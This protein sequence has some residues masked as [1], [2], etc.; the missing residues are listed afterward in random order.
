MRIPQL[1]PASESLE[2]G[3]EMGKS[4]RIDMDNYRF[5]II[6]SSANFEN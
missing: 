5:G 1:T 2:V 3:L 4:I 6:G